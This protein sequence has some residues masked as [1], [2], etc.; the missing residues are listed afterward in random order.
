MSCSQAHCKELSD[1]FTLDERS[2]SSCI[3]SSPDIE[4]VFKVNVYVKLCSVLALR[5]EIRNIAYS[6]DRISL[7][8]LSC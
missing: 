8:G 3:N 7:M 5:A 6:V 2:S 1:D 4:N